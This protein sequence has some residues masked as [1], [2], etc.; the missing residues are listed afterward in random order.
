[1]GVKIYLPVDVVAARQ[2][3]AGAEAGIYTA[4]EIP[5]D[6]MALDIGPATTTLYAEALSDA[7]TVLWNGPMGV[8]EMEAFSHGTFA[9]SHALAASKALTIVGGGDTGS[10][11]LK[12]GDADKMSYIATGG[13]AFLALM[14][15]RTLPAVAALE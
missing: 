6:W 13:G 3:E 2:F 10:A 4:Q 14:E 8:F 15:G 7:G 11:V 1:M 12:A 5:A 9:L